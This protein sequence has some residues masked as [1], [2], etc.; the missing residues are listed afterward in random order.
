MNTR[1]VLVITGDVVGKA[2]AG[3]GIRAWELARHL[4]EDFQV[5]LA[6][7]EAPVGQ[8]TGIQV[9]A[10]RR[11]PE[12]LRAVA[13]QSRMVV[14]QG[15]V[16]DYLPW[17]VDLPI[18]LVIDVYDPFH[19]ETLHLF[20]RWPERYQRLRSAFDLGSIRRQLLAGDFFI[21]ASER[22]RDFWLGMLSALGRL[23]PSGY[24][25]DP[26]FRHLIDVVPFGVPTEP[27][28]HTR[29]VL[30]G[31]V[32]GIGGSDT[33]LLWGGGLWDW[34]D[35]FTLLQAVSRLHPRYPQL[36]VVFLGTKR[37]GSQVASE[38]TVRATRSLARGLGLVDR[39]VFFN[40]WAD[41]QDRQNFLLEADIGV[42]LNL[43]HVEANYAFRTRILD[44]IWT[45]L[46]IVCTRGDA[47]GDLV[48]RYGL[49]FTVP[50]ADEDQVVF[51]LQR[52][53]DDPRRRESRRAAFERAASDLSWRRV[54]GPLREFA[55]QP[56]LA[57]DATR[58]QPSPLL[59]RTVLRAA[60]RWRRVQWL[61]D[62]A[63]LSYGMGGLAHV[64]Y[65]LRVYLAKR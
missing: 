47:T 12:A 13:E 57:A 24:A 41:Y 46:P 15:T 40:D 37:P 61:L 55:R 3:T 45:S 56:R 14:L 31:G 49:G 39:A 38:H 17:L 22:Q 53:L 7:P 4:A 6:A 64:R 35:P 28:C 25:R 60:Q 21:C 63:R 2:M 11:H 62:G 33:V 5:V 8:T 50:A 29:N 19:L 16:L 23:G 59:K 51:A 44:Y 48:E 42:S 43:D 27:A 26:T 52:L 9:I 36:K 20:S 65:H 34:L 58:H 32:P 30:K 1:P 54:V 18:P 10:Y